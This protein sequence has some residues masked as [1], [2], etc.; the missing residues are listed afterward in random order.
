[1]ILLSYFNLHPGARDRPEAQGDAGAFWSWL[2]GIVDQV[3]CW[4]FLAGAITLEPALPA[5]RN[6]DWQ[7]VAA[8]ITAGKFVVSLIVAL[9]IFPAAYRQVFQSK[10][11]LFVR[12]GFLLASGLGWRSLFDAALG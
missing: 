5:I 8:S 6:L 12:L 9:L 10:D 1:M 4:A 2:R 7:T 3:L 11:P